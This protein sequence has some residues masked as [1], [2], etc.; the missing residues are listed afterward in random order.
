RQLV[1]VG[2]MIGSRAEG[3]KPLFAIGSSG[4]NAALAAHWTQEGVTSA[5]TFPPAGD[6]GPIA[7]V[8]GSMSPVTAAQVQWALAN[9]FVDADEVE[10]PIAALRGGKSVVLHSR[11]MTVTSGVG[12]TL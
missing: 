11:R 1:E 12:P 2:R 3:K 7:A 8:C 6:V 5:T 9:G 4:L 10:D